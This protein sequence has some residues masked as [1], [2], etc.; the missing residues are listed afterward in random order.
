MTR[1]SIIGATGMVGRHILQAAAARGYQGVAVSRTPASDLPD[2]WAAVH[3]DLAEV[4]ETNALDTALDGT[5]AVILSAAA[6]PVPGSPVAPATVYDVNVRAA[7][8]VA[9]WAQRAGVPLI[10][11]SGATVYAGAET[12]IDISEDAEKTVHPPSGLYG[13]SKLLSEQVLSHGMEDGPL[14]LLRPTSV[15]GAGMAPDKLIASLLRRA[16]ADEV[17]ELTP[18]FD[19]RVDLVHGA[20]VADAVLDALAAGARGAFNVTGASRPSLMELAEACIHVAGGGRIVRTS[21]AGGAGPER[22][23]FALDGT[24]AHTTFGYRAKVDLVEGLR[25]MSAGVC[26]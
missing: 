25:R 7:H 8:F 15:Y 5:E 19:D 3:L 13:F 4:T 11:L 22:V 24:K 9:C 10:A 2:G 21:H 6:V 26:I 23:R 14:C 16:A 20:D 12:G 17:I 1:L 18:P